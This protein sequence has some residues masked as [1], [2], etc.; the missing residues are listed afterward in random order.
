MLRKLTPEKSKVAD[1]MIFCI[2]HGI[3]L[4][5]CPFVFSLFYFLFQFAKAE[6]SE[7]IIDF[8]TESLNSPKTAISKKVCFT[9]CH[10]S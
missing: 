6:A 5:F 1:A 7:E 4:L 2:E 10:V 8:I 3:N 9:L